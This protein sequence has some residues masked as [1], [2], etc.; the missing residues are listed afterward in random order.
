MNP[1]KFRDYYI[2]LLPSNSLDLNLKLDEFVNFP[3]EKVGQLNISQLDKDFLT[4]SGFP[5][6]AAPFLSFGLNNDIFLEPLS[7]IEDIPQGSHCKMIGHNSNGD[8][9][10]ID[11][12]D[13]GSIIYFNHDLNMS[14]EFIN[15]SVISLAYSLCAYEQFQQTK[16]IEKCRKKISDYDPKAMQEDNFWW[17]EINLGM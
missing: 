3:V 7:L 17:V 9:I 13:A 2:N 14:R 4:I 8:I 5:A 1:E 10:C 6:D 12:S 11:E 16:D 15:S